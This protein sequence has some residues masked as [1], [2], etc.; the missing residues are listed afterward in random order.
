MVRKLPSGPLTT[1]VPT[2]GEELA[3]SPLATHGDDH[4]IWRLVLAHPSNALS[5][6]RVELLHVDSAVRTAPTEGNG[7]EI[8]ENVYFENQPTLP[9]DASPSRKRTKP[10]FTPLKEAKA[11]AMRSI[12]QIGRESEVFLLFVLQRTV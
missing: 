12:M 2:A 1:E 9:T 3:S 5:K 8:S 7:R 4:T 6:F 10:S 11:V